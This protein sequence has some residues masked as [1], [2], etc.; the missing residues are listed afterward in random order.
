LKYKQGNKYATI[1]GK[2]VY[3]TRLDDLDTRN[4]GGDLSPCVLVYT[5]NGGADING[6]NSSHLLTYFNVKLRIE[7]IIFGGYAGFGNSADANVD[8]YL[9]MILDVFEQQ[10][11]DA[12]FKAQNDDA[13]KFR[14]NVVFKS[15]L[16][17][18]TAKNAD[19]QR[20]ILST[21]L[22]I[23]IQL[24]DQYSNNPYPQDSVNILDNYKDY[25]D[26]IP[27]SI[28]TELQKILVINDAT[29]LEI[30]NTQLPI[31]TVENEYPHD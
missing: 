9:S 23:D 26:L 11:V 16:Q 30:V 19:T 17:S 13:V 21:T 6:Q 3:D 24:P 20:K 8:R 31:V 10:V 28:K 22:E 4:G 25:S 15:T 5:D 18:S 29:N 2:E 14:E 7:L 27:N 12:L 1:A